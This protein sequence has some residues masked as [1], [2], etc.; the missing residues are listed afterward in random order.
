M[1]VHRIPHVSYLAEWYTPEVVEQP[2][3]ELVTRLQ[4]A[5]EMLSAEGREVH[6][7]VTLSVP[8]DQFV[9]GVFMA[10]N[11]AD[12]VETCL[13]AGLPAGRLSDRI[14][15]RFAHPTPAP[16]TVAGGPGADLVPHSPLT[17]SFAGLD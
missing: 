13:R 2:V 5:A 14:A 8:G 3:D 12:V 17:A 16:T 1:S 4:T 7:A 9:Y 10:H 6:V 11:R 15:V